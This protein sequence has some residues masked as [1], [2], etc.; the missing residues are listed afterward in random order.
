[1]KTTMLSLLLLVSFTSQAQSVLCQLVD[2]DLSDQLDRV[3][4]QSAS[5]FS[6]R[7]NGTNSMV[8]ERLHQGTI[9]SYLFD[10]VIANTT[11]P[12]IGVITASKGRLGRNS[13]PDSAALSVR[14]DS[15]EVLNGISGA[16]QRPVIL[17]RMTMMGR[18]HS[19]QVPGANTPSGVVV[20]CSPQIM[21]LF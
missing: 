7:F 6:L 1:M 21:D 2:R 20:A 16:G 17:G 10:R 18:D 14:L 15:D 4:L 19:L 5:Y 3:V 8:L 11:N 12:A 9:N 13:S